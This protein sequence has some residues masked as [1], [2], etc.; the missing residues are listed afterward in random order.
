VAAADGRRFKSRE[1]LNVELH[2]RGIVLKLRWEHAQSAQAR[3]CVTGK[4]HPAL[5]QPEARVSRQM[6]WRADDGETAKE[7]VQHVAIFD[8]ANLPLQV[9][10]V[11]RTS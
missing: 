7:I 10:G 4:Q 8:R 6:S 1:S 3:E 2:L 5:R 9:R 11:C